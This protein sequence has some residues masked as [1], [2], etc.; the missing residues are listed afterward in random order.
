[1]TETGFTVHQELIS[2]CRKGDRAAQ[3]ELYGLYYKAMFNTS[4][5]MLN[6]RMEAEDV[7][8]DSFLAAFTKLDQ[9]RGEMPFGAWLKRIVI[10]RSIDVLRQRRIRFEE[11]DER[12]ES[13]ADEPYI[14]TTEDTEKLVRQVREAIKLLPEGFR[15]VLT[16]SLFEGFDHEEIAMVLGITESTS[17]SQ[18]ARA[19]RKLAEILTLDR[20]ENNG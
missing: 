13:E 2:K 6:N 16:L 18:L 8:Q 10:N 1:M 7:M 20:H 3:V 19:K 17:R 14:Q 4:L 11:L 12:L 15:V 9:Y 5:R